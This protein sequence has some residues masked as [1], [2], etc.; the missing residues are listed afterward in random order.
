MDHIGIVSDQFSQIHS[1]L[2]ESKQ[3]FQRDRLVSHEILVISDSGRALVLHSTSSVERFG[4]ICKGLRCFLKRRRL[5]GWELEGLMGHVTFLGRSSTVSA[6][7]LASFI[8][9]REP[10]WI[11]ARAE[12]EAF[13]GIMILLELD[14]ARPWLPGV[15]ASDASL[16]LRIST[17]FL[18]S[19][20]CCR[21]AE[22]LK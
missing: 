4:R 22:F 16:W 13:V 15:L 21:W 11:S 3:D 1:A 6:A 5:A 2:D 18:E 20:R 10:L 7:S 19:L 12:L 8:I 9:R 14:W 17:E